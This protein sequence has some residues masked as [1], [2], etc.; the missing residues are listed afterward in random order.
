MNSGFPA[1]STWDDYPRLP[2]GEFIE[3]FP[4]VAEREEAFEDE[5]ACSSRLGDLDEDTLLICIDG[6]IA[7]SA[8][9]LAA[10]RA[11]RGVLLVVDGSVAFEGSPRGLLYASG[12]VLCD[13]VDQA[14][15]HMQYPVGGRLVAR[16]YA[17]L[18]ADD[19]GVMATAASVRLDTPYLFSW[20]YSLDEL[21]LAPA[22]VVFLMGESDYLA[23]LDL[24]NPVFLYHDCVFALRP[25]LVTVA[26]SQGANRFDWEIGPIDAA[27]A[28][29]EPIFIDGFTPACMPAMRLAKAALAQRAWSLAF[30]HYRTAASL[31]PAYYPAWLG[32]GRAL[33][34]AAAFAQALEYYRKASALFPAK[35][36]GLRNEAANQGAACALLGGQFERA[37]ELATLSIAHLR[38]GRYDRELLGHAFNLRAEARLRAGD[39][40]GARADLASQRIYQPSQA[41]AHWL[42]GLYHYQRGEQA[43]ALASHA[44]AVAGDASFAPFY[45]AA[46][47]LD[48]LYKQPVLVDWAEADGDASNS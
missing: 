29:G 47:S 14:D 21:A 15:W 48:F 35:Q 9:Q 19:D 23:T 6:D 30:A 22:T 10:L 1:L 31:S 7:I 40:Q 41:S 25:A 24:P 2:V 33:R 38:E 34:G 11:E 43:Q 28:R 5:L 4:E 17:L 27:L 42:L 46:H 32:M 16:R 37:S 20:F 13:T 3:R 45:D 8:A 12:D 36:R 18:H 26:D 39:A 44:L